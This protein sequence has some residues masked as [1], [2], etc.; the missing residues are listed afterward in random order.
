MDHGSSLRLCET[1]DNEGGTKEGALRSSLQDEAG[2]LAG[3]AACAVDCMLVR[4]LC[5]LTNRGVASCIGGRDERDV[6]G[7]L[8]ESAVPP[9]LSW[10]TAPQSHDH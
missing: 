10:Q 2:H 5:R 1:L 9:A 8:G 4:Y 6:P 7:G 3:S